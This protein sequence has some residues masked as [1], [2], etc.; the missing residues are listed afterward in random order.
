[1]LAELRT[2]SRFGSV[3]QLIGYVKLLKSLKIAYFC[4]SDFV[5]KKYPCINGCKKR[6]ILV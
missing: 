2:Q 4:T 3:K 6:A 1:M 5:K